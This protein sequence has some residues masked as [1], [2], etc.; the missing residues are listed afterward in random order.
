MSIEFISEESRK[1]RQE[2]KY[3]QQV[4][5]LRKSK[6]AYKLPQLCHWLN[7]IMANENTPQWIAQDA[8]AFLD[9]SYKKMKRTKK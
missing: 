1:E 4:E 8:E 2:E 7:L 3:L 6:L 5:D 9:F